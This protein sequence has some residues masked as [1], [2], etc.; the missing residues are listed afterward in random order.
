M[1]G[2]AF[3]ALP[4]SFFVLEL[5][6][7]TLGAKSLSFSKCANTLTV[8][9]VTGFAGTI[10]FRYHCIVFNIHRKNIDSNLI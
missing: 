6:L 4:R 8:L 1:I 7:I 5:R 2:S 3:D 10:Y 9:L